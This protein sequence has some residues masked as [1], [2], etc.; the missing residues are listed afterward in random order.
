MYEYY[1]HPKVEPGERLRKAMELA[2]REIYN[3]TKENQNF[4]RMATTMVAAVVRDNKLTIANVGDSRAYLIRDDDIAQLTRDHSLKGELVASKVMTESEAENS[5]VKNRLTR[6]I[7]GEPEVKVDVY[8]LIQLQ[9]GDRILLC[10][11]GLTRYAQQ[12]KIKE[13]ASK[14]TPEDV[15][16]RLVQHANRLGG[17]DN[18]SVVLVNIQSKTVQEPL[19][20]Q[21]LQRPQ[22]PSWETMDTEP[23]HRYIQRQPIVTGNWSR[24]IPW[25]LGVLFL[26]GLTAF[27][28]YLYYLESSI[29]HPI[30]TATM[31]VSELENPGLLHPE[32]DVQIATTEAATASITM[33]ATENL[34]TPLFKSMTETPSLNN[35]PNSNPSVSNVVCQ[36]TIQEGDT[37]EKISGNFN[38]DQKEIDCAE[39][40]PDCDLKT[41]P[42]YIKTGWILIIPKV[43]EEKCKELL[44]VVLT[45]TP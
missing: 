18:I 42:D 15:A 45:S 43:S 12:E 19:V 38:V 33:T 21:T 24:W 36:Y 28:V 13:L 4:I 14:G 5:T 7:G 6:S 25:G 32:D 11:D 10:S 31:I 8:S 44:G 1:Q 27:G 22:P 37:L 35:I 41:D 2:N 20:V 9:V 29:F 23:V 3:F 34:E 40:S 16:H 39:E 30:P 17:A 26:T